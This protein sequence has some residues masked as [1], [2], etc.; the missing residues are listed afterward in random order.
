MFRKGVIKTAFSMAVF[1]TPATE[2]TNV[3]RGGRTSGKVPQTFVQKKAARRFSAVPPC[4]HMRSIHN[5][6]RVCIVCTHLS[7]TAATPTSSANKRCR[8]PNH[9]AITPSTAV[10]L[11]RHF[12]VTLCPQ[13]TTI[14]L[15]HTLHDLPACLPGPLPPAQ[16]LRRAAIPSAPAACPALP[17]QEATRRRE[18]ASA[19]PPSRAASCRPPRA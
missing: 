17:K 5:Q 12:R 18:E 9:N 3:G 15:H 2:G 11:T 1:S 14:Y 10:A 7:E 4:V 19:T 13:T 6:G 16:R 8:H